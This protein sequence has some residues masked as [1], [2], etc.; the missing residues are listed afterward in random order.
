MAPVPAARRL[1]QD[2]RNA[3]ILVIHPEDAEGKALVGQLRRIGCDV[4]A[5]W[6]IPRELP[7]GTDTVFVLVDH[8]GPGDLPWRAENDG[9]AVIAVVEY[10]SPTT[11]SALL[12]WHAHAVVQRPIRPSGILSSLVLARHRRGFETRLGAKVRKLE[13]TLRARREIEKATRI[14]MALRGLGEHEAYALIRDQATARRE[15]LA[16]VAT[17]VIA[18]S[19]TLGTLGISLGRDT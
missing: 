19:D 13:E 1:L 8:S 3:R 2:L 12:D 14:L 17:R 18:A 5:A 4:R 7:P 11:L 9:P 15:S 16:A 10:E 6:P